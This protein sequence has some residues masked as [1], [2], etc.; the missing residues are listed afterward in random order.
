ML[1]QIDTNE[2]VSGIGRLRPGAPGQLEVLL[3]LV[4]VVAEIFK[5]ILMGRNPLEISGLLH[6]LNCTV[7]NSLYAQA[8]VATRSMT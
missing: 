3:N 2:G 1:V 4:R 5:P 8:A 7:Y 6:E